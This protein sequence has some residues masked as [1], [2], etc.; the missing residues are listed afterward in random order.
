SPRRSI[1]PSVYRT[2][3]SPGS[4]WS[5]ASDAA[6]FA[7]GIESGGRRPPSRKRAPAGPTTSGGGWPAHAYVTRPVRVS[8][9]AQTAVDIEAPLRHGG[10][11][12]FG[13][14]RAGSLERLRDLIRERLQRPALLP[15]ERAHRCE[16]QTHPTDDTGTDAERQPG[17]CSLAARDRPVGAE[18]RRVPLPSLVDRWEQHGSLRPND[19][20][21]RGRGRQLDALL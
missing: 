5:D 17:P 19:V 13:R 18:H 14:V 16:A 15:V 21:D 1:S 11:P 10:D 9:S 7:G 2:S 8:S 3:V 20:G 6:A 4:R 12:V